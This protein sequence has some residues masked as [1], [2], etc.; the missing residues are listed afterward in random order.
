MHQCRMRIIMYVLRYMLICIFFFFFEKHN[1]F[2][3]LEGP[4]DVMWMHLSPHCCKSFLYVAYT[5][6][7]QQ[8]SLGNGNQGCH[9]EISQP[10]E[11]QCVW[12]GCFG[13]KDRQTRP[14][15]QQKTSQHRVGSPIHRHRGESG[16]QPKFS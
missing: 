10:Y 14:S 12:S 4:I 3:F 8:P 15:T 1:Y 16:L 5:F 2:Y 11:P 6:F 7:F 13:Q 9:A